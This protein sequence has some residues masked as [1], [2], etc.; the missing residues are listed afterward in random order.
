MQMLSTE[1]EKLISYK[2]DDDTITLDDVKEISQ[3]K[4]SDKVLTQ[5]R[6]YT[7]FLEILEYVGGLMQ[8]ILT[9]LR[10]ICFSGSF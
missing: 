3:I 1:L 5:R 4:L 10:I 9:L 7:K 8:V 2:A 6:I